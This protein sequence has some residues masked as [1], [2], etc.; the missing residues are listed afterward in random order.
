MLDKNNIPQHVA[1]IMDGNGRW[2][3][4][5]GLPRTAGHR[6]GI[7]RVKDIVE[8][9]RELGVKVVTFFAFSTENWDRPKKEIDM[10]MRS[11]NRFLD[12]QIDELNK[13]NIRLKVIGKENPLPE[14]LL[15]KIRKAERLTGHNT[16]LIMVLALNYGA[17]QEIVDA[18]KKF[19]HSVLKGEADIEE[20]DTELFSKYLYTAGLPDPDLLIRTSGEIRL[21]NFL[22]WQLSYA[23]LYF[24][25]KYWPDF[26]RQDFEKA[27]QEYQWMERRFGAIGC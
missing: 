5:R 27:I 10:L 23:E 13:N 22:L 3:K 24:P 21:S 2:A 1:I 9:S 15:E 12:K 6:E 4:A 19:T 14:Y 18:A 20:L 17:R 16:G 25:K 26:K 8:A 11:L 7:E